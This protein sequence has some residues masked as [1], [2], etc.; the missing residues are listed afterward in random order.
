MYMGVRVERASAP[1]PHQNSPY[2]LPHP[3]PP[4]HPI[5]LFYFVLFQISLSNKF[6]WKSFIYIYIYIYI[7]FMRKRSVR[8]WC[9]TCVLRQPIDSCHVDNPLKSLSKTENRERNNSSENETKNEERTQTKAHRHSP[10]SSIF[11]C[12]MLH[13][14]THRSSPPQSSPELYVRTN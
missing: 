10:P 5:F 3:P 13:H 7:I 14:T 11:A 12:P 4:T 6:H 8:L 1:K 2:I 9:K